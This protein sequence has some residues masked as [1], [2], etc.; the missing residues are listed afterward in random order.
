MPS[1]IDSITLQSLENLLSENRVGAREFEIF[2]GHDGDDG[3]VV[4]VHSLKKR[5]ILRE[6]VSPLEQARQVERVAIREHFQVR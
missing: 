1:N 6:V 2:G 4:Y 3:T 5:R